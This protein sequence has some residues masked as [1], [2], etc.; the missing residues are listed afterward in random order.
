MRTLIPW[1]RPIFVGFREEMDD[2]VQ[3]FFGKPLAETDSG[4]MEAWKPSCDVE[5]TDKEI[6]VKADLPGVESKDIEVSLTDNTLVVRGERKQEKEEKNKNFQRMERFTG[7]FY[8]EIPLPPGVDAEKIAA[9]TANGVVTVTIPKKPAAQPK[10][11]AVKT[12]K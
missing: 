12:E 11:I 10:K 4:L 2:L 6:L 8:R 5:E 3:R 1:R 7:H 9:A